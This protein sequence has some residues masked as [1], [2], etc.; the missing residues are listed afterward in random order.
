M[1]GLF[2]LVD[3]RLLQAAAFGVD[4]I[5]HRGQVARA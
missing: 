4:G 2:G 3:H 5:E 1:T